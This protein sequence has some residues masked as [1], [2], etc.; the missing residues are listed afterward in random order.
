MT[1]LVLGDL[2]WELIRKKLPAFLISS[3][4]VSFEKVLLF[5]VDNFFL[6]VVIAIVLIL[7]VLANKSVNEREKT[8]RNRIQEL[9][10]EI[11]EHK[12]NPMDPFNY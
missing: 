12:F 10:D 6:I 5:G 8:L 9:S 1:D 2:P 3:S 7:F 11:Q 4:A